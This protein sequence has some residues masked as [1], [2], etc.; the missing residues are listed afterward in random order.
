MHETALAASVV[1]IARDALRGRDPTE[2]VAA[3]RLSL[4]ALSHVEPRALL[5]CFD[6]AA[7]GTAVEGAR[8]LIERPGG[9][10]HCLGCG[11]DDVALESRGQPCPHCGSHRLL[12]TGGEDMRVTELELA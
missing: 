5:F 8:L 11:T 10:A 1:E 2:R 7:R 6:A 3:V 12:V 4:G 9:R